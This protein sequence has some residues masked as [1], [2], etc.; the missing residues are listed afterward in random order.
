MASLVFDVVGNVLVFALNLSADHAENSECDVTTKVS[1][2]I[3]R[4]KI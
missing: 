2:E 1:I 3:C 4:N